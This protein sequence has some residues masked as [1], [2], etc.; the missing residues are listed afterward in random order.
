MSYVLHPTKW[1]S[2]PVDQKIQSLIVSF[3][4][5]AD[6]RAADAGARLAR[7]VFSPSGKLVAAAG[8]FHGPEGKAFPPL[9]FFLPPFF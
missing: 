1:P 8:T 2:T 7:E 6:S 9:L 4:E 5:L 3:Y